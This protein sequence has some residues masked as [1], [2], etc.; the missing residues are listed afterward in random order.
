MW[1]LYCGVMGCPVQP[2]SKRVTSMSGSFPPVLG[3]EPRASRMLGKHLTTEL[4]PKPPDITV[5]PQVGTLDDT[6]SPREGWLRLCLCGEKSQR[7]DASA[8]VSQEEKRRRGS[9]PREQ[10]VGNTWQ[11]GRTW[12]QQEAEGHLQ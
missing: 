5:C 10:S 1:N 4:H 3:I 9:R 7:G 12:C 8:D 11:R 6:G 2:H